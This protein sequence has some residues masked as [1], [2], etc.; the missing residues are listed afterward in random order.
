MDI[1]YTV[2]TMPKQ[3]FFQPVNSQARSPRFGVKARVN[4]SIQWRRSPR[5]SL[6]P[7][8]KNDEGRDADSVS[9]SRGGLLVRRNI[10]PYQNH[11]DP[12]PRPPP[13]TTGGRSAAPKRI[14]DANRAPLRGV[15]RSRS[16]QNSFHIEPVS[17]IVTSSNPTSNNVGSVRPIGLAYSA[18]HSSNITNSRKRSVS[19]GSW[20]H[21]KV[22][23]PSLPNSSSVHISAHRGYNMRAT[24]N[25]LSDPRGVAGLHSISPG[26]SAVPKFI[27]SNRRLALAS[28][29][30]TSGEQE[31]SPNLRARPANLG[32]TLESSL[33]TRSDR[34]NPRGSPSSQSAGVPGELWLDTL[35]LRDWISSFL[36][37]GLGRAAP[38]KIME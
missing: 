15:A 3:L 35:S 32:D 26:T 6:T 33:T 11:F 22:L 27:A 2:T 18:T 36:S 30:R 4:R 12:T 16:L 29:Q 23:T 9:I 38:G 25:H 24:A 28:R 1:D 31:S 19:T 8:G 20:R 7:R 34:A 14:R 37:D 21:T 17:G 5:F 10:A 13:L